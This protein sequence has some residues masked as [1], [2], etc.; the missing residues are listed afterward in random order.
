MI[1]SVRLVIMLDQ[2]AAFDIVNLDILLQRLEQRCSITG[3]ALSWPNSYYTGRS[4]KVPIY[5]DTSD[6]VTLHTGF[7]HPGVNLRTSPI[8]HLHC[9]IS[10]CHQCSQ[11][12]ISAGMDSNLSFVEHVNTVMYVCYVELCQRST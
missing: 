10:L 11:C 1:F 12:R 6:S 4:Q 9:T 8:P 5:G 2:S 7:S 3:S